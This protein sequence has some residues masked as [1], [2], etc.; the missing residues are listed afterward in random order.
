MTK[1]TLL[2]IVGNN[3][4]KYR[5]ERHMTQ[6]ELAE[7]ANISISYCANIERGVKN[8]SLLVL[9]NISD[10]LQVST[11]CLL[12]EYC[13]ENRILNLNKFLSQQPEEFIIKIEHK[14]PFFTIKT[15]KQ[16]RIGNITNIYLLL[17]LLAIDSIY[18]N[19]VKNLGVSMTTKKS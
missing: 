13:K 8:M 11:D 2:R 19:I 10:A 16:D 17:S 7:R 9:R 12:Y 6:D 1:E 4:K 14:M 18:T 3:V 5:L 15:Y